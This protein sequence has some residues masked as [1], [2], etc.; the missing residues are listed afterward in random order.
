[1]LQ[2]RFQMLW[3]EASGFSDLDGHVFLQTL[4]RTTNIR[5]NVR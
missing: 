5:P 3:L 2:L 4:K 1:M